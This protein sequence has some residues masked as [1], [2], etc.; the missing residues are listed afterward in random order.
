MDI[1]WHISDYLK[2]CKNHKKL[3]YNTLRA[4]SVDM[5]QFQS[6]LQNSDLIST[7]PGAISKEILSKYVY[8]LQEK[9]AVKTCKRKIACLKA[10]F[11]H[12]EVEDVIL[13]N[14]FRK[15]RIHMKDAKALPKT[16]STQEIS[17]QLNY[18]YQ[19]GRQAKTV[20]ERFSALVMIVCYELL[21]N[22]GM[23]IGELCNLSLDSIDLEAR[24]IRIIGK[25]KR[26]RIAYLTSGQVILSI[27]RYLAIR[28]E[29]G[30][31]SPFFLITKCGQ[32]I[33]EDY[34]RK[35]IQSIA[36]KT[37]KR[38]ITPHMFRHTFASMLLNLKV[39]IRYIQEL[40]GHSSIS[41]TQIYLHLINTSIRES[42]EQAHLREQYAGG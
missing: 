8:S 18:V 29:L 16:I 40:L 38:H 10:F 30:I 4:Y 1:F 27:R 21:I 9:Y 25:G 3:T 32:K 33:S 31:N 42:L 22:T 28:N 13:I 5:K 15:I 14:P 24:C 26:E 6:F 39:D 17:E 20:T 23:R 19:G 7:D 35:K 2:H 12:L 41:T 34:V 37:I 36:H 11:N